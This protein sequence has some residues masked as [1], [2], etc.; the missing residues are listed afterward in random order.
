MSYP[1]TDALQKNIEHP[2]L[3]TI[4]SIFEAAGCDLRILLLSRDP[5]SALYS[6]V[7]RHHSDETVGENG[8]FYFQNRVLRDNRRAL[9]HQI[10]ATRRRL[11]TGQ[12]DLPAK[13][14]TNSNGIR[15]RDRITFRRSV[16]RHL[17]RRSYDSH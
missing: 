14:S 13:L 15:R 6:T 2:S 11:H 1:N 10:R 17:L 9:A 5:M 16:C 3:T 8:S 4:A 7:V 12:I